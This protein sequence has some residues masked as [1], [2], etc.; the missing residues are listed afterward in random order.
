MEFN[1][2]TD[3]RF[4]TLKNVAHNLSNISV[5]LG[6]L[7][8]QLYSLASYFIETFV[9]VKT[10]QRDNCFDLLIRKMSTSAKK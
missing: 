6:K 2:C 9:S 7:I 1:Y 8:F 5:R 10:K 4:K 3:N